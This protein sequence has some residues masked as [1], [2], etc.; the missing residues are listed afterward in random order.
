MGLRRGSFAIN[1]KYGLIFI[2]GTSKE[3]ISLHDVRDG[4]RL[5]QNANPSETKFLTYNSFL[6]QGNSSND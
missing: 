3:K 6:T 1:K 5:C 4:K 2:G